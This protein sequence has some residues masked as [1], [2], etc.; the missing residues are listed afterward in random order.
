MVGAGVEL[1]LVASV[2]D[3]IER[4]GVEVVVELVRIQQH[5]LLTIA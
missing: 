4:L 5:L 2:I 3:T 1:V